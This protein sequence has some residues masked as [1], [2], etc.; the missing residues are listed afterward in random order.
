MTRRL[1]STWPSLGLE[2]VVSRLKLA[3]GAEHQ[4]LADAQLVNDIFL[5]T[6]Q[7]TPTVRTIT[8]GSA[9]RHRS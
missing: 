2:N 1:Y 8:E 6:L 5:A 9:A 7:H 3:N 4:A